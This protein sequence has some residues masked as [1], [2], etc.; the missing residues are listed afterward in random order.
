MKKSQGRGKYP[1][2][3]KKEKVKLEW[4]YLTFGNAFYCILLKE[5]M[6]K[7]RSNGKT[8]KKKQTATG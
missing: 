2:Y 8:R 5:D 1:T 4:S 7:D 6:W 3:N